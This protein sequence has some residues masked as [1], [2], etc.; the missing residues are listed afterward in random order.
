[1]SKAY[2]ACVAG[3]FLTWIA[4]TLLLTPILVGSVMAQAPALECAQIQ[5]EADRRIEEAKRDAK[6]TEDYYLEVAVTAQRKM[7]AVQNELRACQMADGAADFERARDA[8]DKALT[9]LSRVVTASR[10]R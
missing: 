7:T 9:E 6:S 1:M 4:T 3:S 10:S 5:A 2:P 8:L